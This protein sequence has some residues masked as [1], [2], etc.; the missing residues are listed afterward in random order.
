MRREWGLLIETRS[1]IAEIPRRSA[2][3][4]A[5]TAILGSH[6]SPTFHSGGCPRA[7]P[8]QPLLVH[9]L[10][11]PS[12]PQPLQLVTAA[13]SV[14]SEGKAT[15]SSEHIIRQPRDGGPNGD[16]TTGRTIHT[17]LPDGEASRCRGMVFSR[18]AVFHVKRSDS[19][20]FRG[21]HFGPWIAAVRQPGQLGDEHC[22]S[23]REQGA[24]QLRY[25][26]Q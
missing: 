24:E 17:A 25:C 10:P 4:R 22:P 7:T 5:E 8:P 11:S 23:E 20:T 21:D 26:R 15:W 6:S 12:N 18:W 14:W 16:C 2:N 13:Q 9:A 19:S 1:L 3:D